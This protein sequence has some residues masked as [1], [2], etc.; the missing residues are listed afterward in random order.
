MNTK[1][2]FKLHGVVKHYEWGGF[3]FIPALLGLK[4]PSLQPCAEL[5]FGAHAGGPSLVESPEGSIP[6][7]EFIQRA[8]EQVL[9][10]DIAARF[11]NKL[12]YLLKI[13]DA[14]KMLSI[15]AHPTIAQAQAGFDA[16]EAAGIPLTAPHRNYKDP[17]HKPE[18]HVALTDFWMLHGFR[19]LAEIAD[20]LESI[21]QFQ[22]LMT[23]FR[24]RLKLAGSNSVNRSTLLRELYGRVMTMSQAEVD[25]FLNPLIKRLEN[26]KPSNKDL[27]DFWAA[28]AAREFPLP[29]GHRDRG[30][31]SIYLLNLVRLHPGEA[32]YQPAG[33]LHAYL[34]GVNVELMANSDNV[35]RG[36][37]TPKNVDVP[38]L[39][40]VLSFEEGGVDI[41]RGIERGNGETV[42]STPAAEFMLSCIT[43][44]PGEAY[45]SSL[46]NGPEIL[47]VMDGQMS[48]TSGEKSLDLNP[49]ECI[50][51][52]FEATYSMQSLGGTARVFKASVGLS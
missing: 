32:T 25:T 10:S 11:E 2:I 37:L 23:D 17:N 47:F 41:I 13:L 43:C 52:P 18:V 21:P 5:W 30:I 33:T 45:I 35:L 3:D 49:G 16:E 42:F 46:R 26:E 28:R 38:E 22:S 31:F 48:A 50:F 29:G 14:R 27:P 20:T 6:L 12:P 8:S 40:R 36:G 34:E 39:M 1:E 51:A 7:P 24:N 15:Q 4:H 44:Q 9:G 19:P